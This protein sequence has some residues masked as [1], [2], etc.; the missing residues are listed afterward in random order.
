MYKRQVLARE[1]QHEF[2]EA[3]VASPFGK[4]PADD[5]D[6]VRRGLRGE[7]PDQ[8]AGQEMAGSD[9]LPGIDDEPRR[10]RGQHGL[11]HHQDDHHEQRRAEQKARQLEA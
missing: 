1:T 5:A 9:L 10:R 7:D 2:A 8:I 6:H 3:A 11:D 4:H